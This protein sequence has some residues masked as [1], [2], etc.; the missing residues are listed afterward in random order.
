M[1]H[2]SSQHF[3][4]SFVSLRDSKFYTALPHIIHSGYFF[5]YI[6]CKSFTPLTLQNVTMDGI[7]SKTPDMTESQRPA[8]IS[9]GMVDEK[10]VTRMDAAAVFL[11][12]VDA[13]PVLSAKEE[14]KLKIKVDLIMIPMVYQINK[15]DRQCP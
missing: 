15:T 5:N 6:I 13:P 10:D 4:I 2:K 8:S 1:K 12:G 7:Y 9:M 14:R 11:N 3:H